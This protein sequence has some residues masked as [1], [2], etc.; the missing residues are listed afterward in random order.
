MLPLFLVILL[1]ASAFPCYAEPF[2]TYVFEAKKQISP[3]SD[4]IVWRYKTFN[5]RLY[6]C[7]YNV[8][9]NKWIGDWE[10]V[11]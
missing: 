9:Q 2:S 6:R 3:Q 8:T 1:S 11:K 7:Q 4:T 5:G 10:L